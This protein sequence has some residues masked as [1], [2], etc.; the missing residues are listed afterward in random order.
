MKMNGENAVT[1]DLIKKMV[2]DVSNVSIESMEMTSKMPTSR[3]R[4]TVT[5][6][7]IS[8]TLCKSYTKSSLATIG[9]HHGKHDHATVLHAVKTVGNLIDTRDPVTT[10]W[11]NASD[12][13]VRE[14]RYENALSKELMRPKD[15]AKLV[16]YWIRNRIPLFVRWRILQSLGKKCRV[17]GHSISLV[18]NHGNTIK[19]VS[20][21]L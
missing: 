6:R 16:K 12:S 7:Q 18:D 3:K 8:M 14:W 17:C 19:A 5:A 10:D 13:K 11:F 21:R 15:K 2:S 9:F 4:E 1:I 20:N